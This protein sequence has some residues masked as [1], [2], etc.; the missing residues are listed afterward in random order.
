MYTLG[1]IKPNMIKPMHTGLDNAQ[2]VDLCLLVSCSAREHMI[3]LPPHYKCGA[4]PI[5]LGRPA[6]R[7]LR[8]RRELPYFLE[9]NISYKALKRKS[10][11]KL[12][13]ATTGYYQLLPRLNAENWESIA[14][15]AARLWRWRIVKNSIEA[16]LLTGSLHFQWFQ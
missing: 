16:A 7:K 15:Y 11:Y 12:E 1:G 10:R 3:S 13:K 6:A 2:N 8:R 9:E 14:V 5:A 4:L